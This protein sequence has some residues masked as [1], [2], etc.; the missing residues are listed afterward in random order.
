MEFLENAKVKNKMGP[1]CNNK[2]IIPLKWA[3]CVPQ[4]TEIITKLIVRRHFVACHVSA[5]LDYTNEKI[6]G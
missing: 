1:N 2:N 5:F 6:S 4:I 3:F